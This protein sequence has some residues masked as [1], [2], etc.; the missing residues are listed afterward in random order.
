MSEN[1]K[2]G[3]RPKLEMHKKKFDSGYR[4]MNETINYVLLDLL[5]TLFRREATKQSL[6]KIHDAKF[7]LAY[8]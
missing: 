8:Q 5:P 1:K 6:D 2:P 7:D 4:A 3:T